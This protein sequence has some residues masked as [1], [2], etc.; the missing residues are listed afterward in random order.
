MRSV[1][2]TNN[3]GYY[4]CPWAEREPTRLAIIDLFGGGER[5]FTYGDLDRQLDQVAA[6]IRAAG[7][8]RGEHVALSLGNR[9]EFMVAMYGVMRAGA[10]PVPLNTRQGEAVLDY[11]I[12]NCGA[13]G[14]IVE[15]AANEAMAA[16]CER[17]PMRLKLMLDGR[18]EGWA[19]YASTV[20]AAAPLPTTEKL[21]PEAICFLSYTSGSTGRPKGVP[22]THSG[23][24]WW[25]ECLTGYWPPS[26]EARSAVAMPLYHKNAMAGA[27]KPRLFTGGSMVI[28]PGFEPRSY[29]ENVARHRCTH[30]TGVPTVFSRILHERDLLDTLDLSSV[31]TASVGSAP[32]QDALFEAIEAEFPN[33]RVYQ[34]YGLT[35]GGP[36]MI[37]Q[38]TDGRKVPLGSC[39]VAWP[40][41]EVELRGPDGTPSAT[42]GELWVRNPGVTPGYHELPEVNRQRIV[43]GWLRTGDLFRQ[44]EAGFFY[45]MGRSDDMFVCGGENIY[46]IEVESLLLSH[47]A[48][49]EACVVP[50]PYGDKGEA[51]VAMVSIEPGATVDEAELKRHCLARGP[52]FAHPRRIVLVAEMPLSG[53]RKIDRTLITRRMRELC[54]DLDRS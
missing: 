36:V 30:L 8:G 15:P 7:I 48:V 23:Q 54:A 46:P 20:A 35:E 32:V 42:Y 16:I 18:R 31:T 5:R 22:L 13:V 21:P 39:G 50:V 10:V 12:E 11:S 43:D 51:P 52:A 4:L 6:V 26:P 25:L 47:P 24:I 19:D 38:P 29:L 34:S 45:F 44:D 27:G 17:R 33:A 9:T 1:A 41:G 40:E 28:M 53:A 49:V 3:L 37:G 2:S 14:A